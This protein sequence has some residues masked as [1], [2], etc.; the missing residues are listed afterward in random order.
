[1]G[2]AVDTGI[3]VEGESMPIEHKNPSCNNCGIEI[4]Y[5]VKVY[6][7]GFYPDMRPKKVLCENCAIEKNK[8]PNFFVPRRE[9]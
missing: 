1:M 6:I 4:G 5:E 9:K 3:S 2:R 7:R 8:K